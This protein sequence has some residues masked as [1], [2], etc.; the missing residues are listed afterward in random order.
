MC[1]FNFDVRSSDK[2]GERVLHRSSGE[3]VLLSKDHV[4]LGRSRTSNQ[5]RQ[6]S[7]HTDFESHQVSPCPDVS[8]LSAGKQM[9]IAQDKW[10]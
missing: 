1:V 9:Q 5:R 4:Q 8:Y 10:F 6:H 7:F 2:A 3:L